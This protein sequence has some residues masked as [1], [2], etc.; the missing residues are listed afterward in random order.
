MIPSFFK[1]KSGDYTSYKITKGFIVA[2]LLSSFI[3]LEYFG[4]QNKLINTIFI[5]LAYYLLI[6]IDKKSLFFAG[7]FTGLLWFWWIGYS[8]IYYDLVYLIPFIVLFFGVAHGVFFW[9]TAIID[10]VVMRII[11]LYLLTFFEPFGFNWFKLDLPLINTYFNTYESNIKEANL[12]IY[13]P[14]YNIAQDKKWDK[15]FVREVVET[16]LAN[17]DDAIKNGYDIVILPETAFPLPLNKEYELLEILKEKSNHISI[18]TGALSVEGDN[19]LNS[20]YLFENSIFKIANKVVLVPFG[21]EI[22]LP[23]FLVT[24]INDTFFDGASDYA[25]ASA[26]TTFTIKGIKFRNAVCYEAT[27][28][29]IYQNLDT[30]YVIA[31]S[32]NAWFTP[33]TEPTLQK[34]LLRYYAKKYHTLIYHATNSSPNM[35]VK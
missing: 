12:K 18:I 26:P 7:F 3:Y 13:M 23:K 10:K 5:L 28:D 32:N 6:T 21:E 17:I 35:V 34:L 30:P 25:K 1:F 29:A 31:T 8:F 24:F 19:Y 16:N 22:P 11:M 20:T 2:F 9:F 14:S 4:L 33:S 27:T 15:Q